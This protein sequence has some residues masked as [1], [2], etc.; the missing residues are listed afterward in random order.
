MA[1]KKERPRLIGNRG[2]YSQLSHQI[3]GIFIPSDFGSTSGSIYCGKNKKQ[4][5][6]QH[7]E[8]ETPEAKEAS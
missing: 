2:R 6:K 1:T 5:I 8:E 4:I 7:Q 3:Q